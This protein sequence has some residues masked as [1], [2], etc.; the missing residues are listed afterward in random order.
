MPEL[1]A[2][3]NPNFDIADMLTIYS[4]YVPWVSDENLTSAEVAY[5]KNFFVYVDGDFEEGV[6]GFLVPKCSPMLELWLATPVELAGLCED[7]LIVELAD[8]MGDNYFT[9]TVEDEDH[10]DY[11]LDGSITI[12]RDVLD[13]TDV[14]RTYVDLDS[15][16]LVKLDENIDATLK[17]SYNLILVGGPVANTIV[18]DL[19]DL[20]ETTMEMWETSEGDVVMLEDVFA[21]G[22]DV[23]IVAG[24]DRDMTAAAAI[25]LIDA[26]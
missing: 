6:D 24:A 5:L 19:V 1:Y 23:L 13:S 18:S 22:K 2:E 15:A 8:C 14:I 12:S 26:L 20:G 4:S 3:G 7:E 17:E 21:V 25:A 16:M 9:L 10:T 11:R